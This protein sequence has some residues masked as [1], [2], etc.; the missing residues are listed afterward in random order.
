L[1]SVDFYSIELNIFAP[2][3]R[4]QQGLGQRVDAGQSEKHP[5]VGVEKD[6]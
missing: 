4:F 2:F 1:L 5:L 6:Q 3:N